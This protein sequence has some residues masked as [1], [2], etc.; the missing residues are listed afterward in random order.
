[1]AGPSGLPRLS[2]RSISIAAGLAVAVSGLALGAVLASIPA[3]DGTITACLDSAGNLRVIDAAD[4]SC[5]RNETTLTWNQAGSPDVQ[6]G[7]AGQQGQAGP[8]GPEGPVG[9]A[10]PTGPQGPV[11]STGPVG[12]Q[13]DNG[14]TGAIGPQGETG[15]TG[16][17]GP[18]GPPGATGPQGDAGPVG[19]AG[20]QGETGPTGA[21]GPAGPPGEAAS[22]Y[23]VTGLLVVPAP[24]AGT[25]TALCDTG[26]R[27]ISGGYQTSRGDIVSAS[28]PVLAP[29]EGWKVAVNTSSASVAAGTLLQTTVYVLCGDTAAPAH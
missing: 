4:S 2:A 17:A 19:P 6:A 13:S 12:P 3:A 8:Q 14:E 7:P 23:L 1:M 22:H 25:L 5:K 11:G 29:S 18:A 15:A 21:T 24:S 9:P 20:P 10:G 16:T 27:L 26:D 28:A